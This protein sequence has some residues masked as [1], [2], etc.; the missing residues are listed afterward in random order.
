MTLHNATFC[1]K[2]IVRPKGA[3]EIDNETHKDNLEAGYSARNSKPA[4]GNNVGETRA[5]HGRSREARAM[6]EPIILID[7]KHGGRGTCRG[8]EI[9]VQY[10]PA[11]KHD[12]EHFGECDHWIIRS[13]FGEYEVYD[14]PSEVD[15]RRIVRQ[16][17]F[18]AIESSTDPELF[19]KLAHIL[20]VTR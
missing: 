19:G 3:S 4:R 12:K 7:W 14:A 16:S 13:P 20:E 5:A 15:I 2:I 1:G 6:N 9:E 18:D 11:D 10:V 8:V 17:V